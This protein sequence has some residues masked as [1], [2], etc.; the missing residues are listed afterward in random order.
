MP[1]T[2][3]KPDG[4][5]A[6]TLWGRGYFGACGAGVSATREDAPG[7][8][9][10][11]RRHAERVGGTDENRA[12]VLRRY[13]VGITSMRRARG[14]RMPVQEVPRA[15]RGVAGGA[16]ERPRPLAQNNTAASSASPVSPI[17]TVEIIL[18]AGMLRVATPLP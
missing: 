3:P 6:Q 18:S 8:G 15:E 2:P 10:A 5:K 4:F 13:D 11:P 9:G 14:I 1:E 7:A 17:S 12:S 16:P